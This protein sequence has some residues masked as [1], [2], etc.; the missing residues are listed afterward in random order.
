MLVRPATNDF[1]FLT[2]LSTVCSTPSVDSVALTL[3]YFT[4]PICCTSSLFFDG[5]LSN[6][7]SDGPILCTYLP[8]AGQHSHSP[9]FIQLPTPSIYVTFLRPSATLPSF[10]C[11]FVG[12]YRVRWPTD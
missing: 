8:T 10:S 6:Q 7:R 1:S 5:C 11:P 12:I 4:T 3:V 9:F 2:I